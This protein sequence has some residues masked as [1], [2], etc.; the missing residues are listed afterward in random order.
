MR[1]PHRG[2]PFGRVVVVAVLAELACSGVTT[3]GSGQAGLRPVAARID[4]LLT[5][6]YPA[7]EPGAAVLVSRAGTIVLIEGYGLA[8]VERKV[9][10][11]AETVF[12]LA[13][14]TKAFTSTA[15]LMLADRGELALDDPVTKLLPAYPASGRAITVRH[16]L[17]HTSGLAEYL[18]R[19]NSVE[20]ASHEYTVQDLVDT[21]KDRPP[22]FAPGQRNVY[23]NS[24]YVLLGAI[25]EKVTGLASGK[26]ADASIFQPLG[27]KSTSCGP[28]GAV[29]GLATA[30][31][32]ARTKDDQLDW[33]SFIV[34]RPYTY[35]SVYAA[36]GCVSSVEDIA[37]FHA[38]MVKGTL[39]GTTSLEQSFAPAALAGGAAGTISDG[40]WQL[41]TI[42]GHAAAMLGGALPGV[43]TWFLVVPEDDLAVILLSN[44]TPGRPRCGVLATEIARI[45]TG[46]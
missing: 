30:Y 25:I 23:S 44:R 17:S 2:M 28:F 12:R 7:G 45:A 21:F 33:G 8:N 16:L 35:S 42:N 39:V 43:C 34:A 10:V 26:F 31:E 19:P 15:I 41:D 37:R 38:A 11:T 4:R 20:W 46:G 36:G 5:E 22:L 24:N 27:M 29:A 40:G 9:P 6:A 14:V 3:P 1:R 32:P 13:S 18:D